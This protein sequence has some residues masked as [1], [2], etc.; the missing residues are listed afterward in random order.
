VKDEKPGLVYVDAQ[1]AL[2]HLSVPP[3]DMK[4]IQKEIGDHYLNPE[5]AFPFPEAA[6][7][8][9]RLTADILTAMGAWRNEFGRPW[10]VASYGGDLTPERKVA[11]TIRFNIANILYSPFFNWTWDPIEEFL[12]ENTSQGRTYV[13]GGCYHK[14]ETIEAKNGVVIDVHPP[15]ELPKINCDAVFLDWFR[16]NVSELAGMGW[17]EAVGEIF[18]WYHAPYYEE[19]DL[20]P[21]I[22]ALVERWD[23]GDYRSTWDDRAGFD[24]LRKG[25]YAKLEKVNAGWMPETE[26]A[27]IA[28]YD[29]LLFMLITGRL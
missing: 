27:R 8:R 12:I 16:R 15:F 7:N 29:V 17:N 10:T 6:N 28:N 9:P 21:E 11:H 2:R 23:H 19:G 24:A 14:E 13:E 3:Y 4:R 1:G 5:T 26:A 22:E 25:L 18:A 20:P